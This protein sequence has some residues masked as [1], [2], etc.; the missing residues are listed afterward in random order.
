MAFT[1]LELSSGWRVRVQPVPPLAVVEVQSGAEFQYP[2]PPL[3]E[4]ETLAGSET[5]PAPDGSPE[6]ATYWA[7]CRQVDQRRERVTRDFTYDYGIAAWSEDGK[8]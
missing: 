4:V 6:Q 8:D 3:V 1:E 7:A 5:V 2:A